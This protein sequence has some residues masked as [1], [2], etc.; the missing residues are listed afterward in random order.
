VVLV[1]A[2]YWNS[3][4]FRQAITALG[5]TYVAAIQSTTKERPVHEDDP[6]PP[7]VSVEASALRTAMDYTSSRSKSKIA[8][9]K[10]YVRLPPSSSTNS[11]PMNSSPSKTSAESFFR[12]RGTTRSV[13]LPNFPLM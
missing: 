1:D 9:S 2:G 10:L 3:S 12:A 13:A 5:L 7:R 11:T 6:K 4:S 8:I